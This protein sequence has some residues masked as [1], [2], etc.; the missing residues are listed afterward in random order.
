MEGDAELSKKEQKILKAVRVN[1][2]LW[3]KARIKALT[4]GKT[5]EQLIDNLLTKYL[6]RKG[7]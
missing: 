7:G 5:M 2:D 4:H 6:K 1:P 3:Q